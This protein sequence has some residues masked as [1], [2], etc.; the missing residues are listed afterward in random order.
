MKQPEFYE[1][2]AIA[3][4]ALQKRVGAR[5][6]SSTLPSSQYPGTAGISLAAGVFSICL[7]ANV[8]GANNIMNY[9]GM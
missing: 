4:D 3:C 9:V 6:N 2:A 5:L 1:A 8:I 7:L